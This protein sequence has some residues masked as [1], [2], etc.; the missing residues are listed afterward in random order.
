MTIRRQDM[1]LKAYPGIKSALLLCLLFAVIQLLL[2]FILGFI[3]ALAGIGTGS[4]FYGITTIVMQIISFGIVI[5]IGIKKSNEK[6][7]D[8]FKFNKVSPHLWPAT[9]I[10]GLGITIVLSEIENILNYFLP[11]PEFLRNAFS[12]LMVEQMFVIS[13]ILI[14]IMPAFTEEMF[15][16][17]LLLNGFNKNYSER[18]S[19][20]ISALLFGLVHMNPWQF[21][22]A[23]IIGIFSAWICIKTK[24]IL[25]GIY[26]HGFNNILALALL[27]YR[28]LIPIKGLNSYLSPEIEFMPKWLDAAGILFFIAGI[29]LLNRGIKKS[30]TSP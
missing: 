5:L 21:L 6:F 24:S 13:I 23:F 30:T 26:M 8:I 28:D 14:G 25:L 1:E 29:L 20:V 16:R 27:K 15:F 7:N 3:M 10:F 2:G 22:S 11:M 18:K 19:I 9:I 17:G 4:I 12:S